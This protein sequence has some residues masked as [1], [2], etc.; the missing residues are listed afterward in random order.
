MPAALSRLRLFFARHGLVVLLMVLALAARLQDLDDL[1]L[2]FH[3]TR[4]LFA[5]LKARGLYAQHAPSI[6]DWQRNLAA[7]QL[8]Q[9]SIIEPPLME[10]LTAWTYTLLG[11]DDLRVPRVYAIL[12]WVLGGAALYALARQQT[13][14]AGGVT[15]AAFYLFLPYGIIA[16]RSFQPDPLMVALTAAFLWAGWRWLERRTW[17]W[18]AVAGALGGLAIFVKLIAAFFVGGA[19]AG[20]ALGAIGWKKALRD[21][22]LWLAG[23]LVILPAAV[24]LAWGL[25]AAGYL[26]Q[27]MGGRFIPSLLLDPLFYLRWEDKI[28]QVVGH[29]PMALGFLGAWM[30]TPKPAR[31]LALGLWGGYGLYGLV[32]NYHNSTHDYYQL[33]LILV[34]ALSLA[35]LGQALSDTWRAQWRGRWAQALM[36]GLLIFV[37]LAVSYDARRT[38]RRVDYRPLAGDYAALGAQIATLSGRD[39]VVA[40]TDDYGYSLAYWAWLNAAV[41]P[42]QSDLV[43]Y[44]MLRGDQA[45]NFA[46]LFQTLAAGKAF[47]VISDFEELSRQPEL[48]AYLQ[49]HYPVFVQT[50][51]FV[52]YD[53]R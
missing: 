44:Q 40:L 26:G 13:G 9:T 33:P 34:V 39:A 47:F 36:V 43:Y 8:Q 10:T 4:Q 21:K 20:L 14:P 28:N 48:A 32:F 50:P 52:V 51:F 6:P 1:P 11:R 3:P 30:F 12:A 7:Q 18:A 31:A 19:F 29:L 35:P 2:D 53:L 23:G 27:Q 41:W 42:A 24:Y 37:L 38:L 45:P 49:T 15:A 16:S 25:W 22:Q 46:T 17:T 5:A